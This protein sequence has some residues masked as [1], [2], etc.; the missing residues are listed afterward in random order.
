M[1]GH[2]TLPSDEKIR[3]EYLDVHQLVG[4]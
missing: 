2:L 1:L 4:Q 3:V